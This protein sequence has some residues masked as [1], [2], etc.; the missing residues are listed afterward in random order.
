MKI[1]CFCWDCQRDGQYVFF[2]NHFWI[3]SH[4]F[5]FKKEEKKYSN[6]Q[7]RLTENMGS[8]GEDMQ[9]RSPA[10]IKAGML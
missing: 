9:Q 4:D 7:R 2:L 1:L 10:G 8:E 5:F 6:W 3:V